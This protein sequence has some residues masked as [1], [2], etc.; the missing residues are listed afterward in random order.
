[1]K[2]IAIYGASDDLVEIEADGKPLDETSQ[3]RSFA[4][5][6]GTKSLHAKFSYNGKIGTGWKLSIE[7]SDPSE[8]GSLPFDVRIVQ[9]RYSPKLIIENAREPVAV[10]SRSKRVALLIAPTDTS[11]GGQSE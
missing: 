7:L 3:P 9:E 6:A 5:V 4:F 8:Q 1:M 2:S 11:T 10:M